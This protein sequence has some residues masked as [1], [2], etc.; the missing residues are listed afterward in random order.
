VLIRVHASTVSTADARARSLDMPPGFGAMGRLV[1]GVRGPRQRILGT[2]VAG[3]IEAVGEGVTEFGPGDEVFAIDGLPM[4]GHAEYKR[5]P[6]KGAIAR[7]P[8]NLT[9]D[10]AA[11]LAFGG[12][13]ALNFLRKGEVKR[14]D[15]VLVNGASGTVG[16]AVVQV[17][18]HLG[19]EVTGVCGPANVEIVRSLGA[20]RVIDYT[21]E[22]FAAGSDTWDVIIDVAG[23][24]PYVRSR[25]A[26]VDGGRL[27]LILSS[28]G[29]VLSAPWYSLTTKHRVVA[30]PAMNRPE[31]MRE[32]AALAEQG[33][34]RPLIGARFPLDQI[35]DAHRLVDTGHK[36]GSVVVV[37]RE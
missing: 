18:R 31:D 23:N 12:T 6:A 24:A 5:M 34:F 35:A 4:G 7:K 27:L 17:A 26:L 1:Y 16:S 3:V 33:H 11:A 19:A 13:T 32:I 14:G 22:D 36:R 25:R 21:R 37:V 2:E 9:F 10:E 30:G 29:S 20:S 15:R 28:L 8:S